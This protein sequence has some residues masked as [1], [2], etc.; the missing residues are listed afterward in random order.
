[1]TL[2]VPA[3]V[4]IDT[5]RQ[6]LLARFDHEAYLFEVHQHLDERHLRAVTL[7]GTAGLQPFYTP[8]GTYFTN[9][10]YA[11]VLYFVTGESR[12]YDRVEARFDRP[13]PRTS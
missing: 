1:M 3:Y 5:L 7:H 12:A 4:Q 13:K 8:V 9:S 10:G 6:A 2:P 11:E